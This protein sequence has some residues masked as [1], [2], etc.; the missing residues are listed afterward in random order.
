MKKRIYQLC[1]SLVLALGAGLVLTSVP[2]GAV[3]PFDTACEGAASN[4]VLCKNKND[5]AGSIIETIIGI[6]LWAIGAISVIMIIV[7]GIRYVISAGD[8]SQIKAARETIL[9]AIVGLVLALSSYAIV[10][11]VLGFFHKP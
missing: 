3:D 8:A 5:D 1:L 6:L 10:Y 4:S 9:Y 2:A 7:G 11:F